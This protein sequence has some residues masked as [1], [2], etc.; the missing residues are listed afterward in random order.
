MGDTNSVPTS[1]NSEI[2]RAVA[3]L[4]PILLI[5][6]AVAALIYWRKEISELLRKLI[7][8]CEKLGEVKATIAGQEVALSRL[9]KGEAAAEAPAL[10]PP[11]LE[12]PSEP[13]APSAPCDETSVT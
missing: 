9:P 5:I 12:K 6:V 11:A 2:I 3:S 13:P 4:W 10:Q 8:F 7:Q 1:V